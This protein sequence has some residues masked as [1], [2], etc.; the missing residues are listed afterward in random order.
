MPGFAVSN[1]V[2]NIIQWP[3]LVVGLA[4]A[5]ALWGGIVYG[6]W[7]LARQLRR[8]LAR[9]EFLAFG[10]WVA[11]VFA[12][13]LASTLVIVHKA[14]ALPR[15]AQ[16]DDHFLLVWAAASG[17]SLLIVSFLAGIVVFRRATPWRTVLTWPWLAGGA[18]GAAWWLG[19]SGQMDA[20]SRLCDAPANSSCD[21]AWGLGTVVLT[22]VAAIVL[23]A[24]FMTGA[25]LRR[26]WSRQR[27]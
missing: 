17:G 12:L 27:I 3:L 2:W 5:V 20:G 23:G 16:L 6:I 15:S 25:T 7:L 18:V 26:L 24:T 10:F 21:N 8:G 13:S 22:A 19:L 14:I 4:F 9:S 1:S 11:T